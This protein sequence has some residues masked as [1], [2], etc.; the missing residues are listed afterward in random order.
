MILDHT[1]V[2]K[3][4]LLYN[5]YVPKLR[6]LIIAKGGI[7]NDQVWPGITESYERVK[8]MKN[9]FL[10]EY[11]G[12][13]TVLELY[14]NFNDGTFTQFSKEIQSFYN[15][16]VSYMAR[17]E[18][19]YD[20]LIMNRLDKQ[21]D[22]VSA[23]VFIIDT[24][25]TIDN[26]AYD[27]TTS[28]Q[29]WLDHNFGY[30]AKIGFSSP[31][32]YEI[33]KKVREGYERHVDL[34]LSDEVLDD[35]ATA[36]VLLQNLVK[37]KLKPLD[38]DS[39]Q[40]KA[41]ENNN[42]SAESFVGYRNLKNDEVKLDVIR[43]SKLIKESGDLSDVYPFSQLHRIQSGGNVIF[44]YLHLDKD[45]KTGN[46]QYNIDQ[47]ISAVN[48][49][50]DER[51]YSEI[52][53]EKQPDVLPELNHLITYEQLPE[54]YTLREEL[55]NNGIH[56]AVIMNTHSKT[57]V[58]MYNYIVRF[59]NVF[60]M[61]EDKYGADFPDLSGK[62]YSKHR[63]V[64]AAGPDITRVV[65]SYLYPIMDHLNTLKTTEYSSFVSQWAHPDYLRRMLTNMIVLVN[66]EAYA[67]EV[68]TDINIEKA[69]NFIKDWGVNHEIVLSADDKS[70][71]DQYQSIINLW[72][73]FCT[74]FSIPF[75]MN[76][77]NVRLIQIFVQ[78]VMF[79]VVLTP[80]GIHIYDEIVPSGAG[81]T[82]NWGT[83]N[84]NKAGLTV[85]GSLLRH[86]QSEDIDEDS[87]PDNT[88][89][90]VENPT[91]ELKGESTDEDDQ[92]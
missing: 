72:L 68:D 92:D 79:P 91:E 77:E 47:L 58:W 80:E 40:V 89:V 55:V 42:A 90:V 44:E 14:S 12:V 87:E 86:E 83:Y 64:K 34:N 29:E 9:R 52:Y 23:L 62:I 20:H 76:D 66:P 21:F 30:L 10:S 26:L 54:S 5:K 85:Q 69:I 22:P 36:A 16:F 31:Y 39:V 51:G 28:S 13:S 46:F 65:Q 57:D 50:A 38:L 11:Y 73:Y 43:R 15:N 78:Q 24:S 17:V 81:V 61:V 4:L 71:F 45:E 75:E 41:L 60:T 70:G 88:I 84:S 82:S 27:N 53:L 67:G 63:S 48:Q 59:P 37:T 8:A 35:M 1:H 25:I 32:Y 74:F 7:V 56:S 2:E 6:E 49:I 33:L 18:A 19:S 3:V